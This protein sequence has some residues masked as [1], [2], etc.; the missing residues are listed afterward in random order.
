MFEYSIIHILQVL[1][2]LFLGIAMTQSGFDKIIDWKGNKSFLIEHFSKTFLS[3]FVTPLLLV[4]LILE[5][6]GGIICFIGV[7]EVFIY[8]NNQ[9]I[10]V[11]LII[12]AI[13]LISLFFGQR[14]AKDYDGAAVLVNYFILTII[15]LLTFTI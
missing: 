7:G 10:K 9:L 6:A 5:L 2:A 14:L 12:I 4:V 1:I 3:Q 8:N 15:G 11:G 13:D